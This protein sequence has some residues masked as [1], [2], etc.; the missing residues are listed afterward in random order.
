MMPILL[1][2]FQE[3]SNKGNLVIL[4]E[5]YRKCTYELRE[6]FKSLKTG[7]WSLNSF[8]RRPPK[9]YQKLLLTLRHD[10]P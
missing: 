2:P 6:K 3:V 10:E 9:K 4:Q 8:L 7:I 5:M 1:L